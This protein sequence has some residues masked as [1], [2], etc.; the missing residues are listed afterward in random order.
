[1]SK[2]NKFTEQGI[3]K[4]FHKYTKHLFIDCIPPTL[5]LILDNHKKNRYSIKIQQTL[6]NDINS[7]VMSNIIERNGL[8]LGSVSSLKKQRIKDL[9]YKKFNMLF[10]NDKQIYIS[11][12][13]NDANKIY[14]A[15][16][17]NSKD[18]SKDYPVITKV[19]KLL[20]DNKEKNTQELIN[21]I[22]EPYS[23]MV[24]DF[25]DHPNIVY[26]FS[27][28]TDKILIFLKAFS[29]D[30]IINYYPVYCCN[31]CLSGNPSFLHTVKDTIVISAESRQL[32]KSFDDKIDEKPED[33]N[34]HIE[35]PLI[36]EG[37]ILSPDESIK[38]EKL[39]HNPYDKNQYLRRISFKEIPE[40][41]FLQGRA[42][43]DKDTTKFNI[44]DDS[45]TNNLVG[46]I[47]YDDK[48]ESQINVKWCN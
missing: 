19:N 4:F 41:T 6:A 22:E 36:K 18:H 15:V 21:S 32:L 23:I 2:I 38:I 48:N 28:K 17:F 43:F 29:L 1:M 47:Y 7:L 5:S 31:A 13:F 33:Q 39:E 9:P 44:Y 26:S 16:N 25:L 45:P 10:Q 14:L 24:I 35:S 34:S 46:E 40:K 11:N 30:K 8:D 20:N 3:L 12:H 27:K 42:K 37:D